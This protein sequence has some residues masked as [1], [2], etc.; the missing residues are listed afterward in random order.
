MINSGMLRAG[1]SLV[2]TPKMIW[3]LGIVGVRFDHFS[4]EVCHHPEDLNLSVCQLGLTYLNLLKLQYLL[5]LQDVRHEVE[6]K[7]NMESQPVS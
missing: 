7:K 1:G 2:F 4:I 3:M 6:P 5:N